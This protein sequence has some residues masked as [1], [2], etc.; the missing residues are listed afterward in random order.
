MVLYFAQRSIDVDDDDD[1]DNG[2]DILIFF[3]IPFVLLR[4]RINRMGDGLLTVVSIGGM[5]LLVL[6]G[7]VLYQKYRKM[8]ERIGRSEAS[9]ALTYTPKHATQELRKRVLMAT[10]TTTKKEQNNEEMTRRMVVLEKENKELRRSVQKLRNQQ[11]KIEKQQH[12]QEMIRCLQEEYDRRQQQRQENENEWELCREDDDDMVWSDEENS[13]NTQQPSNAHHND[14]FQPWMEYA[15]DDIRQSQRMEE[16]EDNMLNHLLM[17][18]LQ[19]GFGFQT[20][21]IPQSQKIQPRKKKSGVEEIVASA[22]D[23]ENE[24]KQ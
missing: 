19:H 2:L 5:V 20:S 22:T 11:R 17:G 12:E 16:Q 10:E 24:G 3:E 7:L 13:N 8:E 21:Q 15:D 14:M 23:E 18:V 6:G 4:R 9:I 1:D